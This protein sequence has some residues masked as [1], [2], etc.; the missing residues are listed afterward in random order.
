MCNGDPEMA[1]KLFFFSR[2]IVRLLIQT[3]L[4]CACIDV[5]F[6]ELFLV[7]L[8]ICVKFIS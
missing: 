7:S 6:T 1:L 5:N 4:I 2:M 8:G 3:I